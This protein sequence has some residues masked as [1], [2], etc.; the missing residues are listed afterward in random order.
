MKVLKH[1]SI[2][3]ILLLSAC[4]STP[5]ESVDSHKELIKEQT[6][7]VNTI[8]EDVSAEDFKGFIEEFKDQ[9]VDCRTPEEYSMGSIDGA[10]NIDFLD[11]NFSEEINQL[12]RDKPVLVFCKSGGRSSKAM[13]KLVDAGFTEVYNL[14]GGYSGWPK[15]N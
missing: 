4:D 6:I 5:T 11:E 9:L 15:Q 2:F 12:D 8:A 13:K 7:V 3:A 10:M 14:L 1:T